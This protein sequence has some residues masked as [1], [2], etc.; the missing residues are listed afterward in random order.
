MC[1][2]RQLRLACQDAIPFTA[3]Y[4]SG[5]LRLKES[6]R[7][8][9]LC[10]QSILCTSILLI[11]PAVPSVLFDAAHRPTS[12]YIDYLPAMGDVAVE[13]P[14]NQVPPHKKQPPSSIPTNLDSVDVLGP[15]GGDEYSSYKK[16]QR[17]LEYIN[18][19]EEYIKDEQ[20]YWT[21]CL[22]CLHS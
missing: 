5:L 15:D 3:H 6:D 12:I 4:L 17:E 14:A 7:D 10:D 8:C 20:R 13:N 22:V 18:L 16:L 19:Q 21:S 11:A 1:S 2:P 9:N